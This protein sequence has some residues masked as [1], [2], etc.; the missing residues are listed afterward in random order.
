MGEE[1]KLYTVQGKVTKVYEP[2]T[3]QAA[4]GSR[5]F[6]SQCTDMYLQTPKGSKVKLTFW[7]QEVSQEL[8]GS[9]VSV[10][11]MS[12]KGV[13]NETNQFSSTK[14]SKIHVLKGGTVVK[15][16]SLAKPEYEPEV[17]E[18]EIEVAE[19][20]EVETKVRPVV[21]TA[22]KKRGRPAKVQVQSPTPVPAT[23]S[24][25]TVTDKTP[26]PRGDA[27]AIVLNN[28]QAAERIAKELG[29]IKPSMQELV[30]LGDMVGRTSVALRIEAGKDRR[31]SEFRR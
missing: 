8:E 16:D 18:P 5:K 17:Q 20:S 15:E 29:Y 11:N 31:M 4:K 30:T 9:E 14:E 23:T 12:Y 21:A 1:N 28:L 3:I 19:T 22:M 26:S 24:A 25:D 6:T 13:Y 7:N 10:T 27:E 2:R